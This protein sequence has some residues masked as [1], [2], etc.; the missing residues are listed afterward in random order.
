M[1]FISNLVTILRSK[2]ILA[3]V[4][5]TSPT[6][7]SRPN[8]I[9]IKLLR[10]KLDLVESLRKI[11]KFLTSQLL[12]PFPLSK[13]FSILWRVTRENC[14]Q[15]SNTSSL[16]LPMVPLAISLIQAASHKLKIHSKVEMILHS[17]S[18]S[19]ANASL[20]HSLRA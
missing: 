1:K 11:F 2:P 19:C 17:S 16:T 10:M 4:I 20:C 9:N 8:L 7:D 6:H 15:N 14:P 13:L 18:R 5:S 12:L 3:S